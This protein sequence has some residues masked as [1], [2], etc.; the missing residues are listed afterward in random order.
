MARRPHHDPL[1]GPSPTDAADRSCGDA[2]P[3]R[4]EASSE[5]W[6]PRDL[7]RPF[8]TFAVL[9]IECSP[10]P[11]I[12]QKGRMNSTQRQLGLKL[13][14]FCLL[15]GRCGDQGIGDLRL[16]SRFAEDEDGLLAELETRLAPHQDSL[17]VTYNGGAYDL[18][19]LRRRAI[20]LMRFDLPILNSRVAIAHL[21]LIRETRWLPPQAS[22]SLV[23]R[24]A[25]YSIS[26]DHSLAAAQLPQLSRL[27]RK[28]QVDV[29]A[30]Y[31]L[32]LHELAS[33]RGDLEWL[34]SGWNASDAVIT[35]RRVSSPHLEQFLT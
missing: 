29:I 13:D 7:A 16:H 2:P 19:V 27:E 18:P 4:P 34:D 3:C 20:R 28:C 31:F 24:C 9:D 21:D 6:S 15:E 17:L 8:P 26:C 5:P 12:N 22:A 33:A 10:D 23:D 25:A 32:F 1:I 11:L 14:G 35:Q 30:T